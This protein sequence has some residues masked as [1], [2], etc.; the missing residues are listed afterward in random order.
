MK[1]P[2]NR[3]K[4]R[5]M[6]PASLR[7]LEMGIPFRWQK[8]QSGNPGGRPKIGEL[9]EAYREVLGEACPLFPGLTFAQVIAVS[10][11]MHAA[12]GNV[13]AAA[14]LADRTEGLPMKAKR[15]FGLW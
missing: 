6:A 11:A 3:R 12:G 14:E 9:S 4:K 7:N 5:R 2:E 8:G 13:A 1:S 15:G 10:M